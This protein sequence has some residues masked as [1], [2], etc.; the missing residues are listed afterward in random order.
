[1]TSHHSDSRRWLWNKNGLRRKLWKITRLGPVKTH[2]SHCR[3]FL[4]DREIH[5]KV[6][7]KTCMIW[8]K[9]A[10]GMHFYW[11][12]YNEHSM[13]LNQ[14]RKKTS[15]GIVAESDYFKKKLA[16]D[17]SISSCSRMYIIIFLNQSSPDAIRT[18]NGFSSSSIL[19]VIDYDIMHVW[20]L[21]LE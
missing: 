14:N 18:Y 8:P 20:C 17:G 4:A 9:K 1:M 16:V 3:I 5:S 2:C 10:L 19:R 11:L 6:M 7:L 13:Q 15:D 12:Q 21:D